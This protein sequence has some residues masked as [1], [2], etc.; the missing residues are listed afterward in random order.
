MS[1]DIQRRQKALA[2]VRDMDTDAIIDM[3]KMT[4]S[5]RIPFPAMRDL[6]V[7]LQTPVNR[8]TSVD[9]VEL[10][11]IPQRDSSRKETDRGYMRQALTAS[12]TVKVKGNPLRPVAEADKT[13]LSVPGE[14]KIEI[15]DIDVLDTQKE[16]VD[17]LG[18]LY[19]YDG[20]EQQNHSDD[21]GWL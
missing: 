17:Y 15:G 3:L 4:P 14:G 7:V 11:S 6:D 18:K 2:V 9:L 20:S 5:E 19:P 8:E 12:Q 21:E 10:M 1:T 16:N 13:T